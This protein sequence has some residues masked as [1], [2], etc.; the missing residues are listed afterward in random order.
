MKTSEITLDP[1]TLDGLRA[2]QLPGQPPFLL[3]ML[4]LFEQSAGE[5]VAEL[6]SHLAHGGLEAAMRVAHMLRS[7]SGNVGATALA[8]LAKQ[9]EM[10]GRA[11]DLAGCRT[12]A[13]ELRPLFDATLA[14][15][16][17]ARQAA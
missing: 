13:A 12:A 5:M 14:A 17:A 3:R 7:T 15:V 2:L 6:E 8:E 9:C 16:L 10:R 11:G 4:D 1:A